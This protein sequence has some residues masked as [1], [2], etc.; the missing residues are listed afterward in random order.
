MVSRETVSF[1]FPRLEGKQNQLVS[2]L[3]PAILANFY[4]SGERKPRIFFIRELELSDRNSLSII[5]RESFITF[6]LV[7]QKTNK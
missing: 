1:V 5:D 4:S 3:S 2:R 7:M 6:R